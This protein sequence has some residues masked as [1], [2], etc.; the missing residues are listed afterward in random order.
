VRVTEPPGQSDVEPLGVI[1]AAGSALT[2]TAVAAEVAEQPFASVTVTL[3]EP[4]ALTAIDGVVAPF[5]HA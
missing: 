3:Y 2:V 1:V 5:D 4:E